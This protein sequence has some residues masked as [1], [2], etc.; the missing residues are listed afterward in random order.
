MARR[1][2]SISNLQVIDWPNSRR[3]HKVLLTAIGKP[4][5]KEAI[6]LVPDQS[7]RVPCSI[8]MANLD[9]ARGLRT[10]NPN[11]NFWTR[12]SNL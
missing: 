4:N 2:H 12:L 3:V 8:A 9:E 7:S 6:F 11:R 1:K 10:P 5:A